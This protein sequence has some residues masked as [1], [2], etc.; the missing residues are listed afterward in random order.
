MLT[1]IEADHLHGGNRDLAT[2][3]GHGRNADM[4]VDRPG[5]AARSPRAGVFYFPLKSTPWSVTMRAC[6]PA[7]RSLL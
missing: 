3:Q 7:I 6:V 5:T 2:L 1:R 4:D